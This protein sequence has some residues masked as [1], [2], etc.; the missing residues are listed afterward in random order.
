MEQMEERDPPK[1]LADLVAKLQEKSGSE[2]CPNSKPRVHT[3]TE[4]GDGSGGK[5]G[6][7]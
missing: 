4:C 6:A 7:P 5:E 2:S 3:N 1:S